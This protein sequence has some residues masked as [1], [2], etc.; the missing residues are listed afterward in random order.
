MSKRPTASSSNRDER[1]R[2]RLELVGLGGAEDRPD[3]VVLVVDAANKVLHRQAVGSDG[4]FDVPPEALK[5]AQRVLFGASD[6]KEGVRAEGAASFRASEFE[7]QIRDGTLALAEGIWGPFRLHWVCASGEVQACRRRSWWFDSII[8]ASTTVLGR[9]SA[10]ANLRAAPLA[11]AAG[12]QERFTPSVAELIAWPYRCAPVCLGTVEVYRRQC[13]CW[14]IVFDDPRIP[15]LVIDLERY[16]ERLPHKLPP[17]R[18]GVPPPPPPPIDPLDTLFFKGGALNELALNAS[19]DL[20][21]LRSMPREQAAQYINGRAYLFHRL[22]SCGAATRVGVGTL[23]PDGSFNVCWLEPLRLLPA[24]CYEQ[25]AY[26]VKQTIGGSTNTIY[27]GLAAGAWFAAGEHPTLTSYSGLAFTC[28]ETGSG[29]DDAYVFLDLIGDTESHELTTPASTGWDRVAAPNAASGLLFPGLGPNDSH[30]RNLGGAVELTFNFSLGMRNPAVGAH[31]Y[32]VSICRADASGNPT[33]T[34][35]Y[36]GQGLA[37]QK[38]VGAD[39]VPESL[40]PVPPAT[41]GGELNL[42]RIPYSDEPWVGSVRYHA[43]INT[44]SNAPDMNLNVPPAGDLASAAANHLITL[45]VFNA[46]GER[47]RPLGTAATGLPGAEVA[48]AFKYRRWFQPGGSP[49]DDTVE[50]PHAALTHLFC[51]DNRPPVADIERLVM[52]TTASNE[53]CQFLSGPGDSEFAIEYRAYVAD[54]RFQYRHSIG[55]LR[56]LNASVANGGLGSLP[57]PL[58]PANVGEPPAAAIVSGSNT[59]ALMLTRINPPTPMEPQGSVTVLPRCSFAVTLTT[60][61]KTTNGESLSYPYATET[62]A[63][64]LA[65]DD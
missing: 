30:L 43:L 52:D 23:Q 10:R 7:R 51:W 27:D 15:E 41:V 58:S 20:L 29:D 55:W 59:F 6:G 24:N 53:E 45:E 5:R 22:C 8:S 42:Y 64:A 57:T 35:Y 3:I 33:G 39:I 11:L 21:A 14:P 49:G 47:L 1:G 36:V 44:L 38:V 17:P 9:A 63:F 65:I 12:F 18:R 16:V 31:Y 25:Y 32:R 48:R 50:V 13:C 37:W 26:V 28:N 61:S 54:E 56:G 40:G 4:G 46:A 2:Y 34:R 60:Q 62:A 19:A